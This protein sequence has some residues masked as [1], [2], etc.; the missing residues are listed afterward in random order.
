MNSRCVLKLEKNRQEGSVLIEALIAIV[1][2]SIGVLGVLSM[3][4]TAVRTNDTARGITEQSAMAMSLVE[5]LMP[6]PYDHAD[7]ANGS[8]P[9][10]PLN[11]GRYSLSWTVAQNA[12][13]NNT[14]TITAT[15]AWT[16]RG[17]LKTVSLMA[18][19]TIY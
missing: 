19:K 9:A 5:R 16:E 6:L 12:M 11:Q 2:F 7:L 15:V 14:K 18:I 8:H 13:I 4:D 17:Q 1:I 3:L 10:T